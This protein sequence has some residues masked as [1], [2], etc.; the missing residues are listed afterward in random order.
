MGLKKIFFNFSKILIREKECT[1]RAESI[2]R[3]DEWKK[4]KNFLGKSYEWYIITP[5]NY[6]YCKSVFNLKIGKEEFTR[7]LKERIK[8][9]KENNENIQ[10][11]IFFGKVKKFLDNQIQEERF[12]EV[13]EFLKELNLEP[14][15][16]YPIDLVY[17]S[18]TIKLAKKYGLLELTNF[19]LF[20]IDPILKIIKCI[21]IKLSFVYEIY[22]FFKLRDF[23]SIFYLIL[24]ELK[25]VKEKT[26]HTEAF[27]RDDMWKSIKN[28]IIGR[29]YT[30]F[31]ITPTNYDYC[32]TYFNLKM[33]KDEFI[34]ILKERIK[35]LQEN[36]EEIQLHIHLCMSKKF[37][38]I[39]LQN[40]KFFEA[41]EF[42]KA[43]NLEPNKIVLGWWIYNRKTIEIAKK[44]HFEEIYDYTI[45]PLIRKKKLKGLTIKYVHKYWHDFDFI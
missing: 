35:F 32:K 1:I 33:E 27:M 36:N 3:N 12:K 5:A 22:K 34:N 20:I 44:Y 38:D 19:N 2:I 42:M 37:L 28:K 16:F 24:G 39:E 6:D 25:N 15:K 41:L 10:L 17:N 11:S 29:G 30:W 14:T 31:V 13:F 40:K 7:I 18:Y 9:L 23:K 45:N 43:L 4:F 26:I 21:G 8:I